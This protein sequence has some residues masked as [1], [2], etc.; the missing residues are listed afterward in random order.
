M[1]AYRYMDASLYREAGDF[2]EGLSLLPE[3]LRPYACAPKSKEGRALR[4]AGLVLLTVLWAS[5]C[6]H[7]PLPPI[8]FSERGKPYFTE[9]GYHFNISHSKGLA[10][11]ALSDAPVGVDIEPIKREF[12]EK[13]EGIARR[14]FT[15]EERR[16]L[17][18]SP[19]KGEA[20]TKIWVRKEAFVKRSGEGAAALSSTDTAACRTALEKTVTD[21]EGVAYFLV[22]ADQNG[23]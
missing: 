4:L 8:A 16:L 6:G 21:N 5:E 11:C 22:I 19:D 18:T 3:A 17:A 10:L 23:L 14:F 15:E 7:T 12:A 9:G 1:I 2:S 20:F 13:E